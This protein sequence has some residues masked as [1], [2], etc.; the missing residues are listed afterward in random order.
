M[1]LHRLREQSC[2]DPEHTQAMSAAFDQLCADL[3][4]PTHEQTRR[5]LVAQ[6]VIEYA[7]RMVSDPAKLR[8]FVLAAMKS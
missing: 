5:E 2:F 3:G 7:Q 4:L 6:Q 8:A 1:P